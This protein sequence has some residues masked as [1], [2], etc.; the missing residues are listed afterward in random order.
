MTA[1][2]VYPLIC[3]ALFYLGSRAVI[4]SWLWSRYPQ[5]LAKFLDCAAC[6]GTWYGAGVAAFGG[7]VLDLDFLTLDGQAPTTWVI[8][9][10]C[11]MI[12]TPIVASWQS[13]ALNTLGSAVDEPTTTEEEARF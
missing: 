11:A 5:P 13:N 10:L 7:L 2:V 4:T 8:V 12:W 9:G 3:A 1:V 6:A